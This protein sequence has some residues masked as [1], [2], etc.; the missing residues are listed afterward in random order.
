MPPADSAADLNLL[1]LPRH[2]ASFGTVQ[3][4]YPAGIRLA[5]AIVGRETGVKLLPG[6]TELAVMRSGWLQLSAVER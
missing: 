6:E 4:G 5:E 3:V 2:E 1:C